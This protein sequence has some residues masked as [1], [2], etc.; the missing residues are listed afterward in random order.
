MSSVALYVITL[1]IKPLKLVTASYQC[2]LKFDLT[3][4]FS[5]ILLCF[6]PFSLLR[7]IKTLI[8]I[9]SL[10]LL[11]NQDTLTVSLSSKLFLR[12]NF[13]N[14]SSS[15]N[16]NNNSVIVKILLVNSSLFYYISSNFSLLTLNKRITMN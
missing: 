1:L 13:E 11:L 8:V 16:N 7:V 5:L 3:C 15:S 10:D 4:I 9:F 2:S 12:K 14:Y 6:F